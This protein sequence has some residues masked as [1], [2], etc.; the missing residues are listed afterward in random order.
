MTHT[1]LKIAAEMMKK[2]MEE[3]SNHGC[4]DYWM[5]DTPEHRKF[6]TAV[7]EHMDDPTPVEPSSNPWN[8]GK[9][10]LGGID[11]GIMGYLAEKLEDEANR[12]AIL[13]LAKGD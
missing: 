8:K 12:V 7:R 13:E 5:K 10:E 2:A 1:E 6:L 3:F 4:G 9:K 11:W